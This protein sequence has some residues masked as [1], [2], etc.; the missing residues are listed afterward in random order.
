MRHWVKVVE[1][2]P[3]PGDLEYCATAEEARSKFGSSGRVRYFSYP[4]KQHLLD[5]LNDFHNGALLAQYLH[6]FWGGTKPFGG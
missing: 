6:G 2:E 4:N 3:R 5:A 1:V